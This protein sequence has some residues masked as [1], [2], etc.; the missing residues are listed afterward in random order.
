M[1]RIVLWGWWGCGLAL[2]VGCGGAQQDR[3]AEDP[4]TAEKLDAKWSPDEETWAP[5]ETSDYS[6]KPEA[7]DLRDVRRSD[8]SSDSSGS[9]GSS[10]SSQQASEAYEMTFND[11]QVLANHYYDV[12]LK[13]ERSKIPDALKGQQRNAAEASA[14]DSA[15]KG[16]DQWLDQCSGLVGSAYPREWLKCAMAATTEK[17]FT[18]CATGG[19]KK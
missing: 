2:A 10:G 14:G 9:P 19:K 6:R 12:I 13:E 11:C 7:V 5:G 1:R 15:Q 4:T 8:R 3:K 18:D 16:K 17:D